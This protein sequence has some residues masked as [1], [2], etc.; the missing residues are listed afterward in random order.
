M[1]NDFHFSPDPNSP[2]NTHTAAYKI[3]VQ[4]QKLPFRKGD[5]LTADLLNMLVEMI[6][7]VLQGGRGINVRRLGNKVIIEQ[8]GRQIIPKT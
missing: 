1:V 3:P 8:T 2:W 5:P 4:A 7:H 6:P